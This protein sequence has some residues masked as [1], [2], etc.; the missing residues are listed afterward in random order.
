MS[1]D[2]GLPRRPTPLVLIIDDTAEIRDVYARALTNAGLTVE[3]ARDGFEGVE[4]SAHLLPDVVVMDLY[5]PG[6]DGLRATRCLKADPRTRPIPVILCTSE[7]MEG[8]ALEAGCDGF[9][10]KPCPVADVTAAVRR[11]LR[12][13]S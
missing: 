13:A 9:V 6:L 11:H 2:P 12:G 4:M 8:L 1:P 5:M 3:T 10:R 7:S